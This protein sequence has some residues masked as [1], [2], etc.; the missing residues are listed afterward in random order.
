[1][2]YYI[3]L[4]LKPREN[5]LIN[6]QVSSKK[7]KKKTEPSLKKPKDDQNTLKPLVCWKVIVYNSV[8]LFL[9]GVILFCGPFFL[10]LT[11]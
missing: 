5:S 3:F 6:R 1:M 8:Y 7:K 9:S 2:F 4:L 11:K 10:N